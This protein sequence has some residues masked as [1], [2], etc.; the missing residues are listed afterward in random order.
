MAV[1]GWRERK[2]RAALGARGEEAVVPVLDRRFKCTDVRRSF[3]PHHIRHKSSFVR[4]PCIRSP[5]GGGS[6][7]RGK[8]CVSS[9]A[10]LHYS[11]AARE[12][13]SSARSVQTPFFSPSP[14]PLFFSPLPLA[15]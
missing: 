12:K 15:L 2:Q 5:G 10:I 11:L 7:D 6:P 1:E 13:Q 9:P 4:R 8:N 3:T 14:S